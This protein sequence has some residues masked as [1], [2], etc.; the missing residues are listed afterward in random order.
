MAE[1]LS[2]D[3]NGAAEG[4][5]FGVELT[6]GVCM[7]LYREPVRLPCEHSFCGACIEQVFATVEVGEDYRCPVCRETYPSRPVMSKHLV[8]VRLVEAYSK[9]MKDKR[10][11]T[12]PEKAGDFHDATEGPLGARGCRLHHEEVVT[13]LCFEEW[14]LLC[15][16]CVSSDCHKGHTAKPLMEIT[17][18]WK[19]LPDIVEGLE[20][21]HAKL[22][23]QIL[24]YTELEE[25]AKGEISEAKE[26]T[27][28][29][30]DCL[31]EFLQNEKERLMIDM[32]H[33]GNSHLD[34]IHGLQAQTTHKLEDC[35]NTI[36]SFQEASR[37]QDEFTFVKDMMDFMQRMETLVISPDDEI[38]HP[39]L[40]FNGIHLP[41]VLANWIIE[42]AEEDSD[43][44]D[45]EDSYSLQNIFD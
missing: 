31:I 21:T 18:D 11:Y 30:I 23:V 40:N 24:Q 36:G 4:S 43:D 29:Q 28:D 41:S 34:S 10:C 14:E 9:M 17:K 6:C 45:D 3:E 44:D 1:C 2:D 13:H 42:D 39:T 27:K 8:L 20:E 33:V 38:V 16:L 35:K 12:Q 32:Q 15:P 26:K 25:K 22:S 19:M 7:E 37:V 5:V